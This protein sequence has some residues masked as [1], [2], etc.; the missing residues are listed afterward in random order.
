MESNMSLGTLIR[1]WGGVLGSVMLL[2][3]IRGHGRYR[4]S[5]HEVEDDS[6]TPIDMETEQYAV[7]GCV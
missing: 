3:S 5:L 4:W 7:P 1:I 2:H 6:D